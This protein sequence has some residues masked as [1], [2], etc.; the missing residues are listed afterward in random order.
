MPRRSYLSRI[1]QPLRAADPVVASM[2]RA[3][4]EESRQPPR[5]LDPPLRPR[6]S[7]PTAAGR[8][9]PREWQLADGLLPKSGAR[10]SDAPTVREKPGFVD[11]PQD[12]HSPA[13][14]R[15]ISN[16][17]AS[18]ADKH[19]LLSF[20]SSE[21]LPPAKSSSVARRTN[22]RAPVADPVPAFE[23]TVETLPRSGKPAK[24]EPPHLHI[25]AIEVRV[26]QPP[27]PS[28]APIP[29]ISPIMPSHQGVAPAPRTGASIA[30]PYASRFGLAQG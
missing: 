28:P 21:P 14:A 29:P 4:P 17:G 15:T 26:L 25:G 9:D 12:S 2:P 10:T 30:W 8:T 11:G 18:K 5:P 22:P 20:T 23:R 3:A 6:F 1:A 27:P 13:A 19:D 7:S 16:E 24:R